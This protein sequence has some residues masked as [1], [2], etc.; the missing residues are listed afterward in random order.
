MR[1]LK[2]IQIDNDVTR[3]EAKK[4]K[5][6]EAGHNSRAGQRYLVQFGELDDDYALGI[7]AKK[8]NLLDYVAMQCRGIL[9]R[10]ERFR[11]FKLGAID[12]GCYSLRS[13][14]TELGQ[15]RRSSRKQFD[16]IV[17]RSM[18]CDGLKLVRAAIVAGP[19]KIPH[20]VI[21]ELPKG[22]GYG[23]RNRVEWRAHA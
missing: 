4:I 7:I 23:G 20:T 17:A 13:V 14:A 3:A 22:Q 11:L 9:L 8:L 2:Q 10:N 18:G 15:L 19:E 5:A 12:S 6:L 21:E 16:I 1:S